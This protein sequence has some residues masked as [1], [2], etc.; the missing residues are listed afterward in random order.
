[1]DEFQVIYQVSARSSD[2]E[3]PRV[4]PQEVY[5][6]HAI[7]EDGDE[8]WD[9]AFKTM[10]SNKDFKN[11]FRL[12]YIEVIYIMDYVSIRTKGKVQA[13]GRTAN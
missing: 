6:K 9:T 8:L 11:T 2:V 12:G 4:F 7:N 5:R 13:D 3:S 10:N 1:M